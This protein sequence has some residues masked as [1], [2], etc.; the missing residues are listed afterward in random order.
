VNTR[1]L[2]TPDAATY[3]GVSAPTLEKWRLTG[4]GPRFVHLSARAIGYLREDLD[5]WLETRK[6]SSTSEPAPMHAA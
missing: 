4:H 1:V 3:L 5:S 6:R 2:R